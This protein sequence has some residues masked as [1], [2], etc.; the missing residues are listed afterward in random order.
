MLCLE[1]K[2]KE[3]FDKDTKVLSFFKS[4]TIGLND[5]AKV[6]KELYDHPLVVLKQECK[7]RWSSTYIMGESLMK[8]Q[9]SVQVYCVKEQMTDG[10]GKKFKMDFED[11]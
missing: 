5:L 7:T 1:P 2:V 3:S 6:Q 4:S 9:E 11:S 10:D 8:A